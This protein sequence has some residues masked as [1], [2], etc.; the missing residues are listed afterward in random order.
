LKYTFAILADGEINIQ[1]V[2]EITD[3]LPP[4]WVIE[5]SRPKSILYDVIFDLKLFTSSN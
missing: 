1:R 2:L 4:V 5:D 3:R